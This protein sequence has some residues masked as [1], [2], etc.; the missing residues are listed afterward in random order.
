MKKLRI[1]TLLLATTLIITNFSGALPFLADLVSIP[2]SADDEEETPAWTPSADDW[3]EDQIPDPEGGYAYT[4]AVVGDTQSLLWYD[5]I[6]GTKNMDRM[7]DW[8]VKE[9]KNGKIDLVMGLGDISETNNAG[10]SDYPFSGGQ[11]DFTQSKKSYK[12]NTEGNTRKNEYLYAKSNID[13]LAANGIPYTIVRGNHDKPASTSSTEYT[14]DQYF[15]YDEYASHYADN[16][17]GRY[18]G[19]Y[20][21]GSMHNTYLK[22]EVAGQKYMIVNLDCGVSSHKEKADDIL[23]WANRVVEAN[24]DHKVIVTTHMYLSV[25]G[26]KDANSS[27][28]PEY[29]GLYSGQTI[30]N[31]FARK[32]E[33]ITMIISGHHKTWDIGRSQT[34]GDNGNTV[35]QLMIDPQRIDMPENYPETPGHGG[36]G[37]VAML[38]FSKDGKTVDL[39]YYSTLKGKYFRP[40]NQFSFNLNAL[41]NK[42]EYTDS[43]HTH[44]YSSDCDAICE[45]CLKETRT[46]ATQHTYYNN[47]DPDCNVCNTARTASHNYTNTCDATCNNG[48]GTVR[49]PPHS[50]EKSSCTTCEFPTYQDFN[51]TIIDNEVTI[52]KYKGTAAEVTI[53]ESINGCPVTAI[54]DYAFEKKQTV[55][56]VTIP[57]LVESIGLYAFSNCSKL[58]TVTFSGSVLRTI[59][60]Y[61]FNACSKLTGIIFPESLCYIGDCAFYTCTGLTSID[62]PKNFTAFERYS[63]YGCSNLKTVTMA[64]SVNM[65]RQHTF[66]GCSKLTSIKLSSSLT[67]ISRYAFSSCSSLSEISIPASVKLIEQSAFYCNNLKTVHYEGTL[68]DKA[69]ID[70]NYTEHATNG[71]HNNKLKLAKWNFEACIANATDHTHTFT[72][73]CDTMCNNCGQIRT[74]TAS[75]AYT[76]DCDVDC[77]TCNTQ[78]DAHK[79]DDGCDTSCN[80]C[81]AERTPVHEY[82]GDCDVECDKCKATREA[83]AN[84]TYHNACDEDCNVCGEKHVLAHTYSGDCDTICNECFGNTREVQAKHTYAV[85][86]DDTCVFCR[87]V[88]IVEHVYDN[89]LDPD[90]NDCGATREIDPN[91]TLEPNTD[92][93]TTDGSSSNTVLIVVIIVLAVVAAGTG[94][95]LGIFFKKRNK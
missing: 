36:T 70:I 32:H 27:K 37:L 53:P 29:Y 92:D 35:T 43:N 83:T 68:E 50:F 86:C 7:Y 71:T 38:H 65:I 24:K 14:F 94:I 93:T 13:K 8:I 49:I 78:R 52:T 17:V 44:A 66:Y 6:T 28:Q 89:N 20:D 95:G 39:E 46:A 18:D 1:F 23:E 2:V 26:Y 54:G 75:H 5:L 22:I 74:V 77:N 42:P 51:Y 90:C 57:S 64:D 58:T 73:G 67:T 48:C 31:Q 16:M 85:P 84:H 61:A 80:T 82:K 76:D 21:D 25:D 62:I 40:Q 30:W 72:A 79:Y 69:L 33:N 41:D 4:F 45:L 60:A 15:K 59:N 9:A 47:C 81:S 34:V 3:I 87:T 88:S 63:F 10:K 12:F 91:A 55:T 56:S 19:K 11:F